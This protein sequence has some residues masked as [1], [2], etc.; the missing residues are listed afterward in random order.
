VRQRR[1][2]VKTWVGVGF[3][4]GYEG[5]NTLWAESLSKPMPNHGLQATANSPA[6]MRQG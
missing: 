4:K 1:G 5:K 6:L 3:S 2:S